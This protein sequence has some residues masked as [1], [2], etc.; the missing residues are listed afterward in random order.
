MRGS[1]WAG[2]KRTGKST[3]GRCPM[4]GNHLIKSWSTNQ[5]TVATSSGE[6]ELNSSVKGIS[7]IIGIIN[8]SFEL[9]FCWN[10]RH[11]VDASACKGIM[12]RSGAGKVKHL[13]TRQL[14]I[15]EAIKKYGMQILKIPRDDNVADLLA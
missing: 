8:L 3:S 1:D 15:Q 7:E 2:D 10:V 9:G 11:S 14:W 13:S 5:Q 6:A 12:I 4:A